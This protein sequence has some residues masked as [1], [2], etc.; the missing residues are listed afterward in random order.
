[1]FFTLLLV[2]WM[3]WSMYSTTDTHIP[4]TQGPQ[5][6]APGIVSTTL[7]EYHPS[8][9]AKNQTLYFMR[10]TPGRFDYTILA[11]QKTSNGW[12]I[13]EV[14]PFSG[15]YRD[16]GPTIAHNGNRLFFDSRRPTGTAPKGSINLWYVDRNEDQWGDPV[17]L[18]GPSENKTTEPEAGLDEFGPTVDGQGNLYFYAF[19]QPY[20]GGAH[21]VSRPP[22]YQE[23]ELNTGLPD[24]SASTFVSYAYL[25]EDGQFALLE[26]LA[27]GRRDTDIFCACKDA[28]GNWSKA[29]PITEVNTPAGEGGPSLSTDGQY[30]LFTSNRSVGDQRVSNANLYWI[31]IQ[32]LDIPC[33]GR[34]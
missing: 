14:L 7:G 22:N 32:Q 31:P 34:P 13:P 15:R 29:Y 19:R 33:L 4:E 27:P 17:Y 10:R 26:G 24:P 1:M 6:L 30:L 23:A 18:R 12:A 2:Q 28:S 3:S 5:L 11:S 25:S 8:Y 9:D 16:A 21:Y 20:R